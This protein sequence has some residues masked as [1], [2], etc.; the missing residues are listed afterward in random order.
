M[1]AT[2]PSLNKV[3]THLVNGH[4]IILDGALATYLETLGA[5]ISGALWSADIL[6]QN[7]SLIK[8][9]HLDYFRAGANVAITAS[10]QA[11]IA[12][13]T[14]HL[15]LNEEDAKHVIKKSVSL[16]REAR[17]VYVAEVTAA[18]KEDEKKSILANGA[19][20]AEY[21]DSVRRK[22]FIAGSVGP[23]GAF[24]ADGS[25]YRGDYSLPKEEMKAFH[26]GRIQALVDAGADIL[27]CETIPSKSEAEALLELLVAEFSNTEAWFSFTLRDKEHISDGTP[28]TEIAT[29]FDSVEQVVAVGFNCVADD[30]ALEALGVL[31]P[32]VKRG[33]LVVYPNSGEQWNAQ[34]REWEG[35]RTEGSTLADKTVQWWKAGA[36]M[37]GGCCR[38]TPEDIGVMK[39]ALQPF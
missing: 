6:I 24:L 10:Y 34:A 38:T 17:D 36:T 15:N 18:L 21:E 13:L 23:Y 26:R 8:Q 4:P 2:S 29:L 27:A 32:L 28:L 22:L 25:E 11:S 19:S 39:K 20:I 31:R 5:D 1:A 35:A 9:T 16:A 30:V 14:K 12:G 37:I 3:S 7:P 33:T